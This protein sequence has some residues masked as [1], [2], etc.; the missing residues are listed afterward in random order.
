MSA[1]GWC[2]QTHMLLGLEW[3]PKLPDNPEAMIFETSIEILEKCLQIECR[4]AIRILIIF[5]TSHRLCNER[6]DREGRG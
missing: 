5:A 3:P 1:G 6:Q 2:N 4:H